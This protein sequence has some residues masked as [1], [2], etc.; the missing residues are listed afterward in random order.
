[1]VQFD[2]LGMVSYYSNF[3]SKIHRSWDI[4]LWKCCNLEIRVKGDTRSSK[5]ARI[6]PPPIISY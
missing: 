6:D 4:R 1:M 2:I 5:Q 3:V